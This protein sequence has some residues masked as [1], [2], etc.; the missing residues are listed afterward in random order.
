MQQ[1]M[2][3]L[4][5]AAALTV[6]ML[7]LTAQTNT[8][9]ATASTNSS[10]LEQPAQP[11][12]PPR[13]DEITE[14]ERVRLIFA[15]VENGDTRMT[16]TL[17]NNSVYYRHNDQ[18]ETALTQAI[19]QEDVDMVRLLCR[20]AVINLKNEAGETPLTLAIKQGHTEIIALVMQR[21]KA[22]LKN[23]LDETPLW[24]A[25]ENGDLFIAQKLI[26]KGARVNHLS[27]GE[28]PVFQALRTRQLDMLALLIKNDAD[29][30]RTN[31]DQEIPLFWAVRDKQY[32]MARILLN[33]SQQPYED[34]NWK[35]QI[36]QPLLT[37][38]V[39]QN[40]YDM[41]KLL[42]EYGA[43]V[44]TTDHLDNTPLHT[45]A[46]LGY[47]PLADLLISSGADP[48]SLNMLGETARD[49]AAHEGHQDVLNLFSVREKGGKSSFAA[50]YD[51]Q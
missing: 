46:K 49:I 14:S 51:K 22:A 8:Q 23:D 12:P 32:D 44:N 38:A 27:K 2:R 31:I 5:S 29:P 48:A 41:V 43:Q 13:A 28:T 34:A 35:N 26:D 45:A 24:L 37:R 7:P 1:S 42:I 47:S 39:E 18:G 15:A 16:D 10:T 9:T 17:A 33:R 21:A 11:T 25:I 20:K 3:T 6:L 30:S 40:Q 4:V 19:L 36:G 50:S